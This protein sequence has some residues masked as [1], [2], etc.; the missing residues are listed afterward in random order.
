[1]CV[2][3][4]PKL[5]PQ[6]AASICEMA[7]PFSFSIEDF[8]DVGKLIR[9]VIVEIRK[10]RVEADILKTSVRIISTSLVELVSTHNARVVE[11]E[12]LKTPMFNQ[13]VPLASYIR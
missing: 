11:Y 10:V 3:Q 2:F 4:H 8:L 6:S 12:C 1:M 9:Q 5:E 7:V 13:Y